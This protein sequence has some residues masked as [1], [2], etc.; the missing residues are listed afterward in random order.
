MMMLKMMQP[1]SLPGPLHPQH[2]LHQTQA[3]STN[4]MMA[5]PQ[6]TPMSHSLQVMGEA[7]IQQISTMFINQNTNVPSVERTMPQAATCPGEIIRVI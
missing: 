1:T 4:S 6:L 3:V 7:K 2:H 5:R